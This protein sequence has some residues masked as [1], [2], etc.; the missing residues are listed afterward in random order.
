MQNFFGFFRHTPPRNKKKVL[1]QLALSSFAEKNFRQ[2]FFGVFS[3]FFRRRFF[4]RNFLPKFFRRKQKKT[5][6]CF[7]E[8]ELAW[9]ASQICHLIFLNRLFRC[10]SCMY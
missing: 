10:L 4:G 7:A 8:H 5:P 1:I 6:L 2:N 3:A 9:S